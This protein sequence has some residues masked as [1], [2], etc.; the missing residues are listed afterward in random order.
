MRPYKI[1]KELIKFLWIV[2]SLFLSF[3]DPSPLMSAMPEMVTGVYLPPQNLTE[4]RIKAVE[5][6][7]AL[8]GMNAV[9][10]H[11]KSPQG[12]VYWKSLNPLAQEIGAIENSGSVERT[13]RFFKN[14][15]I[16]TIAKV[17]V[18]QDTLLAENKPEYAVI[19]AGT[20]LPWKDH[21]G[22]SWTNPYKKEV[23]DYTIAL[24]RE[25]VDLGFDEIQFDYVRFPSDGILSDIRYPDKPAGVPMAQCIGQF[26]ETAY[27]ELKPT[28]V[29]ISADIFGLTAWKRDDFGVGQVI[30]KIAPFTD[31]LCPMFYPSHFPKGFL[32][33]EVPSDHPKFLMEQST[34]HILSRTTTK[35]R[36]WIQGFWYTPQEISLQLDSLSGMAVSGWMV[37]NSSGDYKTTFDCLSQRLSKPF[38]DPVFYPDL[39]QLKQNREKTVNGSTRVVNHTD[40][41]TGI[42]TL[43]LEPPFP[44]SPVNFSTPVAV[45]NTLD[46]AILDR[47]LKQ[48]GHSF[49]PLTSKSVKSVIVADIMC[50]VLELNPRRIRPMNIY[51][52]W[53]ESGEFSLIEP[54]SK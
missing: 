26:F 32:G 19:Q 41:L 1:N 18:F 36:P 20:G 10:V 3:I 52:K 2:L 25:L 31:V 11:V 8:S 24:S 34:K 51:V 21:N 6:F 42:S 16:W 28:G 9:V 14:R 22:L 13:L 33:F 44:G 46:E 38:P 5:H 53:G 4:R 50:K 49:G 48:H 27:T 15:H 39:D 40:Y 17:D 37:W 30:E 29:M 7:Y 35:I 23:W 47:L 54:A 43:S 45:V 12:R